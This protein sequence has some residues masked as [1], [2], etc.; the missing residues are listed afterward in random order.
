MPLQQRVRDGGVFG[1]GDWSTR[2]AGD[3][4]T[5]PPA[6]KVVSSS[7]I[8]GSR[9]GSCRLFLSNPEVLQSLDKAIINPRNSWLEYMS[10]VDGIKEGNKLSSAIL[11]IGIQAEGLLL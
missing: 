1:D 2:S 8:R 11:G 5:S 7:Q 10:R 6:V 9:F 3:C 4:G